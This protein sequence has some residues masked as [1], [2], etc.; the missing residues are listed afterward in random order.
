[1]CLHNSNVTMNKSNKYKQDKMEAIF[2]Y[3]YNQQHQVDKTTANTDKRNRLKEVYN[4]YSGF[5]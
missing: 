5:K 3:K 4:L 1:M 2:R